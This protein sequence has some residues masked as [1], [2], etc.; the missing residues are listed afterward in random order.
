MSTKA[1]RERRAPLAKEI[2]RLA[3]LCNDPA[4]KWGAED[5]E[6]WQ[7][8]N[9]DYNDLSAAIERLE[10]AAKIDADQK[11]VVGDPRIGRGDY[12]GQAHQ[13]VGTD[14][15]AQITDEHRSLVMTAWA[16]SQY[17]LDL[18]RAEE[19]ACK[20]LAFNPNR[21]NLDFQLRQNKP[22]SQFAHIQRA[23]Q[24]Y[25][26]RH[27][28]QLLS[29]LHQPNFGAALSGVTAA[30][31][32]LLVPESFM[33][34]LEINMLAYGGVL[35]AAEIM[36]TSTGERIG[37]PTADD[38]TNTGSRLGEN[39]AA[40]T[41]TDP[42]FGL[43][44]WDAYDYTS[45]IVLVPFRL[46]QDAAFDLPTFLGQ[47]L[48]QRLGRKQATDFTN[49]TGA[50]APKGIVTCASVGKTTA[51][52]TAITFGEILD[53]I[54]SVDPAYRNGGRFMFHDLILAEIRKLVDSQSRPLWEPSTQVGAPDLIYGYPYTIS[55][56]MDSTLTATKKVMLF[57]QLSKY[58]V[59]Q[60]A[61]VRMV[62]LQERYRDTDQ[63]GFVCF[64]RADGN[65][66]DAGTKPFKMLKMHA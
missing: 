15:A 61:D 8:V 41:A 2:Q 24:S 36:R 43:V 25:S 19:E 6:K 32:G 55:M 35:Q 3:N 49:G 13:I 53:L 65:C 46:L 62:R 20:L 1:L 44:Y 66:L 11:A 14:G 60:V 47:A 30:S 51:S 23:F 33:A 29:S 50:N 28:G 10:L 18:S 22:N 64:I 42:T 37:W 12:S 45:N 54:H 39:T 9:K 21:K 48:G 38:T 56:E 4:H 57:G 5:E 63:D 34:Q 52:A 40:G 17:S 27:R 16:K 59:R 31:G 58:K 26:E 7:A